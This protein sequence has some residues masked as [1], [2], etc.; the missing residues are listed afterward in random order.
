MADLTTVRGP[1]AASDLG[2]VLVHEH[3]LF[4]YPGS[5]LDPDSTW[6]REGCIEVAVAQMERLLAAGVRTFVDPCTIELGRDPELM[7][8]VSERSGMHVVCA[9]GFYNEQLGIPSYW[10]MRTPEE[11]AD[12]YLHE[13]ADGIG[14]TGIRPGVIKMA[15]S[16]PVGAHDLKVITGAAIAAAESGLPIITHCE[17]SQGG[18]VIQDV[19]DAHGVDLT[20][21]LIGHQDQETDAR[22]IEAAADRGSFVGID[23]IGQTFLAPDEQ[24][25][26]TIVRLLA[27]G[28]L[29]HLCLSQDHCCSLQSP[30]LLPIGVPDFDPPLEV[31]VST[32]PHDYVFTDFVPRLRDAGVTEVQLDRIFTDNPR[33]L[34]TSG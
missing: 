32:R 14:A 33:R 13:I 4:G 30:K 7:A 26:E 3:I 29:D 31:Q 21:C 34:L 23:R 10:R 17:R 9:T 25:V 12:L 2:R 1:V 27:D 22:R 11:V 24:R 16:A 5:E 6:T 20:R 8:E 19:L 15:V 28:Y 18:D